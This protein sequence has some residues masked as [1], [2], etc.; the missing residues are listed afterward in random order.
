MKLCVLIILILKCYF[1]FSLLSKFLIH[2]LLLQYFRIHD[3]LERKN[4]FEIS[5]YL[6]TALETKYENTV[7]FLSTTNFLCC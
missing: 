2:Y 1:V 4:L 5:S 3:K 6:K 7:M